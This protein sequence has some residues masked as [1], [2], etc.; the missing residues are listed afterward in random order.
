MC[1]S[2][3]FLSR[4]MGGRFIE[5]GHRAEE[6]IRK[7]KPRADRLRRRP[8]QQR[9]GDSVFHFEVEEAVLP[10]PSR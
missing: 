7:S 10:A 1:W 9:Q 6:G 2:Y 3:S 8:L 4:R 5:I